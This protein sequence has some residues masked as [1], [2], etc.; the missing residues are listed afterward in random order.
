MIV[1]LAYKSVA[2][3]LM[4][5][6]INFCASR[7]QLPVNLPIK[8]QDIR[9]EMVFAPR[10]LIF[11]GRLDTEKYVFSFARSGRLRFITKLDNGRGNQTLRE[12]LEGLSKIKSTINTNDAYRMATNWLAAM[13]IDL[14]RLEKEHPP[15]VK[16]QTFTSWPEEGEPS[17]KIPLPIFDV[18]WGDW[19][20]P[21]IDIQISGATGELLKLRQE[22]DSY[23][24]RPASLI[25]DMD[26]LLAIPD[27]EFLKYSP[28][29]RSNLV[30]RF[31]A[32]HYP[33]LDNQLADATNVV[34][35][36]KSK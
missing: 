28:L 3:I 7:L 9:N 34:S 33:A 22:D 13:D 30:V 35:S 14:Q 25:K 17:K 15:I 21:V 32:V 8:R 11:A 5:A 4:L 27:E 26:K 10:R 1:P 2:V 12:Y 20:R 36:P 24:K 18:K 19:A 29:E 6:E 16:Q 31:A 23:S